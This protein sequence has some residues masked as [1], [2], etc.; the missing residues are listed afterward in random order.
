MTTIHAATTSGETVGVLKSTITVAGERA[1]RDCRAKNAGSGVD[2][3]HTHVEQGGAATVLGACDTLADCHRVEWWGGGSRLAALA[4]VDVELFETRVERC[5]KN[6]R[7]H[8]ADSACGRWIGFR[9]F[10]VAWQGKLE[11]KGIAPEDKEA[12]AATSAGDQFMQCSTAHMTPV[13]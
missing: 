2:C 5:R 3:V 4:H 12:R 13:S 6:G 9:R 10:F 1:H 8:A 7:G 11:D